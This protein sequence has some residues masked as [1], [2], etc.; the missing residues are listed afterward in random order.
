MKIPTQLK[1][2]GHIYKIKLVDPEELDKD[3]GQ[4][5]RARNTIKI[6]NDLP[7]SQLEETIIHEVLHAING[8]LKEETVDFLSNAIYAVLVDNRLLK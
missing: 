5:N 4:Q 8:D 3:C 2:G 1:I 7:K 6:R